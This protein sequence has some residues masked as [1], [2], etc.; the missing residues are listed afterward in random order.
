MKAF[1]TSVLFITLLTPT[2]F[3]QSNSYRTLR[4]KFRGEKDVVAVRAS[5]G[6]TRTILWMAGER[7]FKHALQEVDE[8][9]LV[10]I[11]KRAFRANDVTLNGFKKI[12]E[13]DTFKE[14]AR[15]K[16]RGDDVTLLMQKSYKSKRHP[17]YNRYLIL[18]DSNEEVVV[19]E[20]KGYIDPSLIHRRQKLAYY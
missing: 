19:M 15:V 17:D 9:R 1:T 11:P 16:E 8:I 2:V 12:A 14:I 7:E 6:L 10:V 3:A 4:E 13:Q 18:V 5:G 20:I